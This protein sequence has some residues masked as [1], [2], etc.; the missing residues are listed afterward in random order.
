MK[1]ATTTA[2]ILLLTARW[3]SVSARAESPLD[4]MLMSVGAVPVT[5]QE[6][7]KGCGNDALAKE[8]KSALNNLDKVTRDI[9]KE[10]AEKKDT[11]P[12]P[13][14]EEDMAAIK[15]MAR[16]M[17]H[18]QEEDSDFNMG[19]DEAQEAFKRESEGLE[20]ELAEIRTD[21]KK[22]YDCREG[23]G[24]AGAAADCLARRDAE[25]RKRSLAA[26]DAYLERAGV[27]LK[28]YR[29]LVKQHLEVVRQNVP[30]VC[31][32]SSF[33]AVVLQLTSFRRRLYEAVQ[34]LNDELVSIC[35]TAN[36]AA[37]SFTADKS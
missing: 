7:Q 23:K 12:G 22:K 33:P 18:R 1:R 29:M 8:I 28:Q 3:L 11:L 20:K 27:T 2:I 32:K 4:T 10:G 30:A 5:W 35:E 9:V 14:S 6:A 19:V 13:P 21:V 16:W 17:A 24:M 31:E 25:L 37:R 15:A 36:E 34:K 26:V